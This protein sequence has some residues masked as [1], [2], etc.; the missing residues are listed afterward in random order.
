MI[1]LVISAVIVLMFLVVL[2]IMRETVIL[3][4]EVKALSQLITEPPVPSVLGNQLPALLSKELLSYNP[5]SFPQKAHII[6][7]VSSN[8]FGCTD[9][10]QE[11]SKAIKSQSFS[12]QDFTLVVKSISNKNEMI[13][14]ANL[15]GMKVVIDKNGK[16]LELCEVRG[17]PTLFSVWLDKMEVF[18][19]KLGGDLEWIHQKL[20]PNKPYAL[21]ALPVA[22]F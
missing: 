13:E 2:G 15:L 6:I 8:C 12:S 3:R 14:L 4:G 19:Y 16:I 10:I 17:T 1:V 11:L 9:L 18:D 20:Y 21:Q 5:A 7:F 22:A